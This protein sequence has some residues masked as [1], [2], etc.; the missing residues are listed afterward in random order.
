[1]H[2]L[3]EPPPR[4]RRPSRTR[5]SRVARRSV[6]P[7]TNPAQQLPPSLAW[8]LRT[9]KPRHQEGVGEQGRPQRV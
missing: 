6:Q 5:R 9:T 3:E 8:S 7:A 4:Q 1:M 2:E